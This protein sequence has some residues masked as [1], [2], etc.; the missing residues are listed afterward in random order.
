MIHIS[1]ATNLICT[2]SPSSGMKTRESSRE[3]WNDLEGLETSGSL[4][5][6]LGR[7]KRLRNALEQ[8][9]A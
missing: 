7:L 2:A 1:A 3:A 5:W 8:K 6:L 4:E 9:V